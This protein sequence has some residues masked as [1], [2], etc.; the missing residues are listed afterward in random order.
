M[1]NI[2][3]D[4]FIDQ[5]NRCYLKYLRCT[6]LGLY[7]AVL[8]HHCEY[9]YFYLSKRSEY[10]ILFICLPPFFP[11]LSILFLCLIDSFRH[12]TPADRHLTPGST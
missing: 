5:I 3:Y 12:R 1:I 8:L 4:N 9:F 10:L 2:K 7:L 6:S 11:A